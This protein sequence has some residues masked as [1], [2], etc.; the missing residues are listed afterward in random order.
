MLQHLTQAHTTKI[1]KCFSKTPNCYNN[2]KFHKQLT[3]LRAYI[4]SPKGYKYIK[5]LL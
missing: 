3:Q 5:D 2:S 4:A 1:L